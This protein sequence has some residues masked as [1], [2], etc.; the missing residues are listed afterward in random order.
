[1]DTG[2]LQLFRDIAHER[3]VSRG[4]ARHGVSQSAASQHLQDLERQLGM[5]LLDRSTRPIA[6]TA[7]GR[8]YLEFC[9]DVLRR[10]SEFEAA[11]QE[12][13]VE[14]EGAVR[15]ASIYSVGLSE[16][17]H[18]EA[19]FLRRYPRAHLEVEYL[20][21]EKVYEAVLADRADLGLVSYPESS[22]ELAVVP[23]REEQ[24]VVAAAP[25][26]PLAGRAALRPEDLSACDFVAFDRDLPIRQE[27][28]RFLRERGVEVRIAMQ[29]DNIP[30]V[31]EA[32]ALGAAVSILPERMLVPD[33][34]QGRLRAI[35]LEADLVRPVGIVYRRKKKFQR[36]AK[37]FLELLQEQPEAVAA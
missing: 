24:M 30:M 12:L 25:G 9:R 16:M 26:H 36:A 19:E 14:V 32:V 13:K 21:P 10:E 7:A 5:V 37:A 31:K 11:L 4:A 22:R 6:L 3:S 27:I 17:S 34:A 35:P 28:D 18:L 8:L 2:H 1:M 20:R 33:I 23:W 15:V 29:F